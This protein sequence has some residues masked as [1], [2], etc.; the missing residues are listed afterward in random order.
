MGA[1]ISTDMGVNALSDMVPNKGDVNMG[2]PSLIDQFSSS[3]RGKE[4]MVIKGALSFDD[5]ALNQSLTKIGQPSLMV[6]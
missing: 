6:N 2:Q 3:S 4:I 1:T 5:V